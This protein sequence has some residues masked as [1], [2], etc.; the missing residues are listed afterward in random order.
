MLDISIKI[1]GNVPDPVIRTDDLSVPRRRRA[2]M[3]E[4]VP[5]VIDM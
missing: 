2:G 4:E 1:A 3:P 5:D